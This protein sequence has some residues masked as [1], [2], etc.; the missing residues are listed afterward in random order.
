MN[1][2]HTNSTETSMIALELYWNEEN[3]AGEE[4]GE[5]RVR[6]EEDKEELDLIWLRL[7]AYLL[8]ESHPSMQHY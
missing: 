5:E 8:Y 7:T 3:G 2:I 4:R 6:D 1:T